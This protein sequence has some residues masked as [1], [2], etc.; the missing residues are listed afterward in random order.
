MPYDEIVNWPQSIDTFPTL[1]DNASPAV[2]LDQIL[3]AEHYNKI[4]NFLRKAQA[5][6]TNATVASGNL[7]VKTLF[8]PS[9]PTTMGFAIPLDVVARISA[10][11]AYDER[12]YIGGLPSQN[13]PGNVLP[14]EFILTTDTSYPLG[15]WSFSDYH[16]AEQNSSSTVI[17]N[18]IKG[19]NFL[20]YPRFQCTIWKNDM[21]Q[22]YA[23]GS[24]PFTHYCNQNF[25]VNSWGIMGSQTLL[26]RG[27]ICDMS[28]THPTGGKELWD[29]YSNWSLVCVFQGI[30][31]V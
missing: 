28:G 24:G 21:I 3:Y 17:N 16:M 4:A 9:D 10:P 12:S 30:R 1:R 23:G 11:W 18:S 25:I 22:F 19:T 14:F 20:D 7:T 26:V 31:S 29:L 6:W 2:G 8:Y 27:T 5:A 15:G 13:I